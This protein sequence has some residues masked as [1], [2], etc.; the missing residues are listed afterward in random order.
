MTTTDGKL[1]QWLVGRL[2]LAMSRSIRNLATNCRCALLFAK[3]QGF[4][5]D[6]R[7]K[8]E[9]MSDRWTGQRTQKWLVGIDEIKRLLGR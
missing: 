8:V 7:V 1:S 9:S 3:Q 4:D 6:I 2:K 5:R